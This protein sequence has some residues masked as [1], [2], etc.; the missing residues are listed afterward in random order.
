MSNSK[1]EIENNEVKVEIE[2]RPGCNARLEVF[3]KKELCDSVYNQAVKNVSKEVSIPGFRKGKAPRQLI[4]ERFKSPFEREFKRLLAE[5]AARKALALTR[6]QP[7][8]REQGVEVVSVSISEEGS[9]VV[10]TLDHY[11]EVPLINPEEIRLKREEVK[12]I[13]EKMIQEAREIVQLQIAEWQEVTDRPVQ[14]EDFVDVD[15]FMMDENPPL[16]ICN[17][18]RLHVKDEKMAPWM[19][20]IIIGLN[21]GESREGYSRNEPIEGEKKESDEEFKPRLCSITVSSIQTAILPDLNEESVK[22]MGANSVEDFETKLIKRLEKQLKE[23]ANSKMEGSALDEV[24][25]L[26]PFEIPETLL[27]AE[28]RAWRGERSEEECER[29]FRIRYLLEKLA[30]H[31]IDNKELIISSKDVMDEFGKQL[32]R[33]HSNQSSLMDDSPSQ[34]ALVNRIRQSLRIQKALTFL[35]D[36]ASYEESGV[37]VGSQET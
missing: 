15:I 30:A 26:Y 24:L 27:K 34:K 6:L 8:K 12:A 7:L 5:T 37:E 16:Q 28:I 18:S 21:K 13:D 25:R 22:K 9:R 35:L 20:E 32:L 36:H 11:P 1:T 33:Q 17:N 23:E 10:L 2:R 29:T 4:E 19:Q 31:L 3:V 14:K